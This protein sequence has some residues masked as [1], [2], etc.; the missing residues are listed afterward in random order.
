LTDVLDRAVEPI[1][2][3]RASRARPFPL[4]PVH[5]ALDGERVLAGREQLRQ[6]HRSA[7]SFEMVVLRDHAAGGNPEVMRP[8][9]R[10]PDGDAVVAFLVVDS[11]DVLPLCRDAKMMHQT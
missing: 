4:G 10:N 11:A 7:V 2:N 6:L 8:P 5:E 3:V 9:R 1:E